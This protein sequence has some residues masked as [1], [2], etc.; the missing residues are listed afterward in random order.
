MTLYVLRHGQTPWNKLKKLQGRMDIPL[1][2]N[3]LELAAKTGE[4]ML[5]VPIDLVISSPL[6][7]ARQT[8]ELITVGRNI[9]MIIDERIEEISFG[10]YEGESVLDDESEVIPADF[11][12]KF[13]NKPLKCNRPPHG[14]SFQ[15]VIERTKDF[16][17]SLIEN[18]E[19]KDKNILISSHGAASRCFLCNFYTDKEDVWRG[20]I[21]PN[22]SV[23]IVDVNDDGQGRVRV[24]DKQFAKLDDKK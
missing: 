22:C 12:H 10:D 21:P 8:A 2:E 11:L 3:G 16:Y 15:D 18:P 4:A 24:L 20:Q 1:N 13:Y 19:Y 9:P 23:T 7:R 6:K 14:E 17:K 5:E